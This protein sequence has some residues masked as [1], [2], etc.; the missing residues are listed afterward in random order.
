MPDWCKETNPVLNP[1]KASAVVLF[2]DYIGVADILSIFLNVQIVENCGGG[3]GTIR[4]DSLTQS[5]TDFPPS[6]GLNRRTA[7]WKT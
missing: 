3:A 2:S 5:L 7:F 1:G 6:T 4:Q